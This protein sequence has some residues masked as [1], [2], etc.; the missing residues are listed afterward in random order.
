MVGIIAAVSHQHT[1]RLGWFHCSLPNRCV[2]NSRVGQ[3]VNTYID[4][5]SH[6]ANGFLLLRGAL[7]SIHKLVSRLESNKAAPS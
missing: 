2:R 5:L 7:S 6:V 3:E 1:G 4:K